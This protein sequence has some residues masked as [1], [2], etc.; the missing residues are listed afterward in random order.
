M[1][2]AAVPLQAGCY[3]ADASL[4]PS[5]LLVQQLCQPVIRVELWAM[6]CVNLSAHS[7]VQVTITQLLQVTPETIRLHG[8]YEVSC[9][10]LPHAALDCA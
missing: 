8:V 3:D 7:Y 9:C 2:T 1:G 10:T 5:L 6:L 4:A